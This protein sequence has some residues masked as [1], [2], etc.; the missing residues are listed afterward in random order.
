MFYY[1]FDPDG[2]PENYHFW[3]FGIENAAMN[4]IEAVMKLM[5]K[6]GML[7]PYPISFQIVKPVAPS[8]DDFQSHHILYSLPL[9]IC[10]WF[11]TFTDKNNIDNSY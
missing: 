5:K 2:G 11:L 4:D 3:N 1:S 7:N 10:T 6:V 9:F 8:Y